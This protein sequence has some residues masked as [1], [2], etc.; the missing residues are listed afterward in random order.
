MSFVVIGAYS[1]SVGQ[2][3]SAL[4]EQGQAITLAPSLEAVPDWAG[5]TMIVPLEAGAPSVEIAAAARARGWQWLGWNCTDSPVLALA[6]YQ[7]G[8][9]AVLPPVLTPEVLRRALDGIGELPHAAGNNHRRNGRREYRYRP[10]NII[11]PEPNTVVEVQE[12]II[13]IGVIHSD[14]TQVLLGLCGPGQMLVSHPHDTCSLQLIAHTEAAVVLHTWEEVAARPDFPTQLRLRLQQLEAWAAMQAR[15][16]L[17]QRL[18]GLLS[19]ENVSLV[20]PVTALSYAAGTLG[21]AALLGE[22][23]SR[24]RWAG[25]LVVCL[26]VTLVWLGRN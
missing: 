5:V 18:L 10:G 19:L 21:A 23:V 17:D 20:V 7:A 3:M 6:A 4:A 2:L 1:H 16:H 26:G 11:L 24:R 9:R 13:A 22:Q 14:G 25:V 12:G 8:A 15:P